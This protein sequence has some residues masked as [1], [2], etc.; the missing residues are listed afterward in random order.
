MAKDKI[1]LSLLQKK[2]KFSKYY[3]AHPGECVQDRVEAMKRKD[4]SFIFEKI[5]RW[6]RQA[7]S[8]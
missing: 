6:E 3:K 7:A 2:A 8:R 5:D 1:Q 4:D